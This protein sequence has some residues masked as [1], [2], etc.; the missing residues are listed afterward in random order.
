[1]TVNQPNNGDTGK[2]VCKAANRAGNSE[3]S[4][5]VLFEGKAHHIAEN[6]HGIYH[7]DVGP[8]MRSKTP[9]RESAP[10]DENQEGDDK[11]G[12]GSKWGLHR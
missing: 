7:A 2:Y 9:G 8:M 5:Y 4:H 6:S 3:I 12:N 11:K 1:M 10:P